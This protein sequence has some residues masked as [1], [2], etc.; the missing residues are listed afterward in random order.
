MGD[1]INVLQLNSPGKALD[2]HYWLEANIGGSNPDHAQGGTSRSEFLSGGQKHFLM[3]RASGGTMGPSVYQVDATTRPKYQVHF[4][5]GRPF[6]KDA[7]GRLTLVESVAGNM[8]VADLAGNFYCTFGDPAPH[9]KIWHHSSFMS[10]K[11][12]GFAGGVII[13][14]GYICQIDIISGHYK[15]KAKQLLWALQTLKNRYRVALEEISICA[16]QPEDR[17]GVEWI[18][19]MVFDSAQ[20]Y[21]TMKSFLRPSQDHVMPPPP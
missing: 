12:V 9:G 4:Q 11:P 13:A 18:R 3:H 8:F 1:A 17:D 6:R 2:E 10:G 14:D 15:P 16:M 5:N 20:K 7:G 19:T 21:L